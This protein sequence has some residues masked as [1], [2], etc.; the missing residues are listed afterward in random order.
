ML[1][2][3]SPVGFLARLVVYFFLTY[4]V[5]GY[6][7]PFYT[8]L[9]GVLAQGLVS[10]TEL[11][12]P[13][14][15]RGSTT[16]VVRGQGIF[17]THKLFPGLRPPG[18]PGDWVQANMV[19][20]LPLMLAT[21]APDFRTRARRLVLAV[22][23]A[24]ALQVLGV[25]VSIKAVWANALGSFSLEHY[26]RFHRK[27]YEFLDAFFQSFDTQL[28]PVA[29]WGGIHFRELLGAFRREEPETTE[30]KS[31]AERRRGRKS[32]GEPRTRTSAS[33]R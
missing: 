31:R 18:I 20:L 15:L 9:L 13:A 30:K 7:A 24:L 2:G 8:K 10:F 3:A 27:A 21:P 19:L 17:F 6:V 11:F 33:E 26:G 5:W 22:L 12:G 14:S 25:V 1:L 4:A 29:I 16:I 23:V 32:Q 28:F